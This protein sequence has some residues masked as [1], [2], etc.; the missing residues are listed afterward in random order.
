LFC[1]ED[2]ELWPC[3]LL[4]R[5]GFVLRFSIAWRGLARFGGLVNVAGRH[6]DTQMGGAWRIELSV[7]RILILYGEEWCCA[8]GTLRAQQKRKNAGFWA[9]IRGYFF[10]FLNRGGARAGCDVRVFARIDK[11]KV[12]RPAGGQGGVTCSDGFAG[13]HGILNR[14]SG[15]RQ[16]Q[17]A[18]RASCGRR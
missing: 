14:A 5:G 8:I 1:T 4:W 2:V 7:V 11:L 15:H 13:N 17:R 6:R 9:D 12:G 10:I 3:G 16:R 18:H